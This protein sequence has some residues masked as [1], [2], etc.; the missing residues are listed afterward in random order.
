MI[1]GD[2]QVF[3]NGLHVSQYFPDAATRQV[4]VS[5]LTD[6]SSTSLLSRY[7]IWALVEDGGGNRT[8]QGEALRC[9]VARGLAIH[10]RGV[11]STLHQEGLTVID[12]RQK[13]KKKTGQPGARKKIRFVKR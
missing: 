6:Y 2:G 10:D 12:R 4:V 3:V 8:A 11:G 7:N 13:E 1:K 5:P 9:A